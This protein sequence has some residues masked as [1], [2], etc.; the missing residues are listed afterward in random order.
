MKAKIL[1][2]LLIVMLLM[3]TSG[4]TATSMPVASPDPVMQE[5]ESQQYL[6]QLG[7]PEVNIP[8]NTPPADV[9]GHYHAALYRQWTEVE[10]VLKAMQERGWVEDYTLLPEANAFR[11]T[12]YAEAAAQLEPLGN[13]STPPLMAMATETGNAAFRHHLEA[14]VQGAQ[15]QLESEAQAR[16]PEQSAAPPPDMPPAGVDYLVRLTVSGE[17]KADSEAQYALTAYLEWLKE[18]GASKVVIHFDLD[19]LDPAEIIAGVGVE[20]DGMRIDEVVR[21]INDIASKYDL[22]GLTVAEPMPR[23]AIKIKNMLHQLPLLK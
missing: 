5:V 8:S 11:I 6:L 18:T 14:A 10:G 22:V 9:P 17:D 7:M 20:P 23:I 13:L 1:S 21:V 15:R 3:P 2:L 16:S 4:I 19:V 12:A